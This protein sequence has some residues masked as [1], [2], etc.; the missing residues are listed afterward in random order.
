MSNKF[1]IEEDVFEDILNVLK[2]HDNVNCVK[3]FGSR[4]R[5]NYNKVSDIDLAIYF[6]GNSSKLKIIRELDE[7]RCILKFDVIDM[8]EI[9]NIALREE[10]EKDGIIIYKK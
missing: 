6:E 8:N 2:N 7:V 10:I 9:T 3:I 4:A 5:G 1:G